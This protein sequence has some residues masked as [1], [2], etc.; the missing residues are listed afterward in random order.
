M[1]CPSC[2]HG[3]SGSGLVVKPH[4][5]LTVWALMDSL[6]SKCPMKDFLTLNKGDSKYFSVQHGD[7]YGKCIKH[8]HNILAISSLKEK[9][10]YV[11]SY[12]MPITITVNG[13]E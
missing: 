10:R 4:N 13:A 1:K 8:Q 3:Y 7:D 5:S 6:C 12:N 2:K 11:K 9:K